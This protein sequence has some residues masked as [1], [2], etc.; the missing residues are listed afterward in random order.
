MK[1]ILFYL[2][3]IFAVNQTYANEIIVAKDGTGNFKTI[4]EA[5]ESVKE[6][7]TEQTKILIKNGIYYEKLLIDKSNLLIVGESKDS[8]IITY[9]DHAKINNMGTSKTYTLKITGNNITLKNL[10]VENNAEPIA[11]AIALYLEGNKILVVN[12]KLLGNQDTIFTGKYGAWQCFYHCYIEGTTDYI[13]G[14][15]TVWFEKCILHCKK[16]SYIT[17]ASTAQDDEFGYI[18]YKC[19]LTHKKG[20]TKVYLGRPWRP[21]AHVAYMK[22]N[23]GKH[24]TPQGWH[25]WNKESNELTAKYFE[26]KNK[27]EGAKTNKRVNWSKQMN[28]KEAKKY[29]MK[30]IFKDWDIKSHVKY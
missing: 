1:Y 6:N 12:C 11:Q 4:K 19:K 27:G 23:L 29:K 8:T 30:Y 20:I 17:A 14:P 25:N 22:C 26:Y 28:R 21:Y 15:A 13:F 3:L 2:I 7:Q 5:I 18:F 24:I 10:S 16:N 9:N